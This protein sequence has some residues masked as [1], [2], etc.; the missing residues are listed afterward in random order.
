MK[1]YQTLLLMTSKLVQCTPLY[2][3][4]P[5][6][7]HT[8][9]L[10]SF[11]TLHAD[12]DCVGCQKSYGDYFAQKQTVWTINALEAEDQLCGRMAW[13]LYELVN[14]GTTTAPDNTER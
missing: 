4:H 2:S 6:G 11:D 10:P 12:L 3:T 1:S 13:A 7:T 5:L 14:V 8:H 9:S